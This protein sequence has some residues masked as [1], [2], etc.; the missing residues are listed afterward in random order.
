M[1]IL[2]A[3]T[4]VAVTLAALAVDGEASAD[5]TFVPEGGAVIVVDIGIDG[6][7]Y[8]DSGTEAQPCPS[9]YVF[10]FTTD[11]GTVAYQGDSGARVTRERNG[12]TEV[13][14]WTLCYRD[15]SLA[16]SD[17]ELDPPPEGVIN[18]QS[19]WIG[20]PAPGAVIDEAWDRV[21]EL[22]TPPVISW[23]TMNQED[24]WIYVNADMEFRVAALAPVSAT[25]SLENILASATATVT[26]TPYSVTFHPG[27]PGGEPTTCSID[28]ASA[29][30][31][32]DVVGECAYRY[33]YSSGYAENGRTFT[34]RMEV[35][36]AVSGDL[37]PG[38]PEYL[39]T[40]TEAEIAVAE[41]QAIEVNR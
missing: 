18:E 33:A 1:F 11:L 3:S 24:G 2:R 40:W 5:F 21:Q 38:H 29:G 31:H 30:F 32:H 20:T 25:A 35:N 36:W 15:P 22:I 23:P 19:F 13:L 4:A 10:S 8:D 7:V 39:V 9:G 17:A 26:A 6:T 16:E 28:G 12:I 14:F 34:Y 41:F 37:P 27:E